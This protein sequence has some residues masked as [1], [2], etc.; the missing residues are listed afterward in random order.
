MCWSRNYEREGEGT[1]TRLGLEKD[2]GQSKQPTGH[3]PDKQTPASGRVRD[4]LRLNVSKD[5]NSVLKKY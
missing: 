4:I 2:K 1:R 3:I 5:F